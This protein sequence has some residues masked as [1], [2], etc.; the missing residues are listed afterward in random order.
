MGF[1]HEH[2][3]ALGC[4]ESVSPA[5]STE[6]SVLFGNI[7]NCWEKFTEHEKGY[8]DAKYFSRKVNFI[9]PN[10]LPPVL[11][12]SKEKKKNFKK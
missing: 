5:V 6:A 7:C 10:A 4:E 12:S 9:L 11:I 1:Y 8:V 3:E 2:P